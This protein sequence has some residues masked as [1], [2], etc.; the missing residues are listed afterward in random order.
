MRRGMDR[1]CGLASHPHVGGMASEPIRDYRDLVAWQRAVELAL[2]VD[3]ICDRLPRRAWKL[4][5]QMRASARS[6][7][8]NIAEGNGRFSTADYLRY[9]SISNA[10]LN[11]LESDLHFVSCKYP[12]I[13]EVQRALTEAPSVRRQLWGLIKSLRRKLKGE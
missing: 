9:L 11:E 1:R 7:H 3:T 8:A 6:V 10:S 2:I 5:A 13:D 4:A 12:L